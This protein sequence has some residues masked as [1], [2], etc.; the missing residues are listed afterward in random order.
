MKHLFFISL[1]ALFINGCTP[2]MGEDIFIEPEGNLR[3]ENS[4][5]EVM[6]GVLALLGVPVENELI[7][8][9]TDVKVLNQW[10]SDIRVVALDYTL[11]DGNEV[12]ALGE[13]KKEGSK[14]VIITSGNQKMI[15]LQFR[16]DPKKLDS[17]RVLGILQSKRKLL[18]KGKAVIEVWGI[19]REY[20]FE[21]EVTKLIQKALKDGVQE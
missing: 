15:P 13:V 11:N 16:I 14:R 19:E 1:M 20:P 4:G 5:N 7:R 10:Y 18:V 9:G 2:K 21:K 8:I 17:K 6:L 3:L 12:I